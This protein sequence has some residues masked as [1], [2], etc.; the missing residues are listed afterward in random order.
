MFIQCRWIT[1]DNIHKYRFKVM[2]WRDIFGIFVYLRGDLLITIPSTTSRLCRGL[3]DRVQGRL[4]KMHAYLQAEPLRT[5][6]TCGVQ[7]E[8]LP[9]LW[10][11]IQLTKFSWVRFSLFRKPKERFKM[12]SWLL[13]SSVDIKCRTTDRGLTNPSKFDWVANGDHKFKL[14]CPEKAE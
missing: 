2:I 3:N 7:K 13:M 12:Q 11:H 1:I 9:S 10:G 14:T 6:D 4:S 8:Q 5:R